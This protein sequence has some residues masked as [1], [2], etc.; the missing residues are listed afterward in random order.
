M[1]SAR[2]TYSVDWTKTYQPNFSHKSSRDETCCFVHRYKK[3]LTGASGSPRQKKSKRIKDIWISCQQPLFYWSILSLFYFTKPSLSSTVKFQF[4]FFLL[5]F[6]RLERTQTRNRN[7][8]Q[9]F[10]LSSCPTLHPVICS[11]SVS[12]VLFVFFRSASGLLRLVSC[13]A[14]TLNQWWRSVCV[15]TPTGHESR[16]ETTPTLMRYS[17]LTL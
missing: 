11:V 14:T 12:V 6:L 13:P 17:H 9:N 2:Q 8:K 1:I 3:T 4:N 7:F 5:W 10:L 15:M 16:E